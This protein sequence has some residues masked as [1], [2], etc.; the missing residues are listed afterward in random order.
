MRNLIRL[1]LAL[2]L[3][4]ISISI[5]LAEEKG[6]KPRE[7]E[8]I[9]DQ[10]IPMED[11]IHL[12][13]KIW[14]PAQMEEPLP[15]IFVLTPYVSDE[16]QQ[17]ATF[18]AQNGYIFVSVDCRGRGNSEGEFYPFEHDGHYGAQVVEWIARQI[19]CDGQVAMMGGSYRGMVQWQTLWYL[20]SSLKTIVPTAAAHPG[21]DAPWPNNIYT[22][23]FT[24][25]LGF[26]T[27]KTRNANLFA[28]QKYWSQKFY[29]MYKNHEP[30][31]RLAEFTGIPSKIFLR[32]IEHPSY[33]DFWKEMSPADED[34]RN[35]NIPILTITGHFDGDQ[36]GA[37]AYYLKHMKF[38]TEEGKARHY[39]FIGPYDHGGTR[40]PE[41]KL[42]GLE[43]ADNCLLD[44]HK[45]HLEWFN[46][47][48]KG[49]ERPEFL[50]KRVCYYMMGENEWKYTDWLEDISNRTMVWHLS[51]EDGKANDVFH[52]GILQSKPLQDNQKPDSFV[53]DPLKLISEEKYF[54][55]N[56]DYYLDASHAFEEDILIYHSPPLEKSLEVAGY[57]RLKLY[58]ELDVPDTDFQA[59][60][61][62]IKPDGTNIFLGNDMLRARYRRSFEKPELVEPGRIDL[63]EFKRFNFFARKIEK[64]SRL[65]LVVSCLNTPDVGKNYNSGGD[66]AYETAK[67]ARKATIKLYH[68]RRYPST[69]ELPVKE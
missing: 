5:G 59:A 37:M 42:G 45:L 28:D 62:E 15:A 55:Q 16:A 29:K 18:F 21:I 10:K 13:A 43:F 46:W 30:F 32:W 25:W 39:L 41:K 4:F 2:V 47:T 35:F 20:P 50:K 31:A 63:Y 56:P 12:A 68:D 34:Y 11:G 54:K 26:V 52:S 9:L 61:Y 17:R 27:G 23:Y 38:G 22:S 66:V 64:G 65:R 44:M 67:D 57:I 51:S 3:C 14:K 7:I 40:H 49:K 1:S 58:M 60:L 53:Y 36:P 69:L 19:W 6:S 8:M 48:L 33:D 24:R